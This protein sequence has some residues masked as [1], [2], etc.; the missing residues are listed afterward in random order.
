MPPGTYFTVLTLR[1]RYEEYALERA[2][3]ALRRGDPDVHYLWAE[4]GPDLD[5]FR[6]GFLETRIVVPFDKS[7]FRQRC[8]RYGLTSVE[9]MNRILRNDFACEVCSNPFSE[10]PTSFVI[11]HDHEDGVPRGILCVN[12][13]LMLTHWATPGRLRRAARYLETHRW[14]ASACE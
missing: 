2:M 10:K 7:S 1:R 9:V 11:D 3:E 6:D 12:C 13:N 8:A 4:H 5:K 14:E